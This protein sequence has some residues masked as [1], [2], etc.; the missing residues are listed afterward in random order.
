MKNESIQ[1]ITLNEEN[2]THDITNSTNYVEQWNWT[3]TYTGY[4]NV[5]EKYF[6][7]VDGGQQWVQVDERIVRRPLRAP[8]ALRNIHEN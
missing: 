7:S 8:R 6:I 4:R 1:N 2:V 3:R 5:T